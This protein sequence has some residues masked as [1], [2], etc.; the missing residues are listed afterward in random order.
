MIESSVPLVTRAAVELARVSVLRPE[1]EGR[2]RRAVEILEAHAASPRSGVI[3]AL[4]RAGAL[5]GFRV[6]SQ[7]GALPGADPS[8]AGRRYRVEAR[9]SWPCSCP[10]AR[11]HARHRLRDASRA[12]KHALAAWALWRAALAAQEPGPETSVVEEVAA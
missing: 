7:Q 8:R 4:L 1:L 9:G 3:V 10:D 11:P 12:C 5:V 6:R 2:C